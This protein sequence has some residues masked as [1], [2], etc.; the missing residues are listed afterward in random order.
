MDR[1]PQSDPVGYHQLLRKRHLVENIHSATPDDVVENQTLTRQKGG[2]SETLP[3]LDG[4]NAWA[5]TSVA[6]PNPARTLA[7]RPVRIGPVRST[8]PCFGCLIPRLLKT[9]PRC[10]VETL[11]MKIPSLFYGRAGAAKTS[12]AKLAKAIVRTGNFDLLQ[13]EPSLDTSHVDGL[14]LSAPEITPPWEKNFSLRYA[15]GLEHC[16]ASCVRAPA[17]WSINDGLGPLVSLEE[18][19]RFVCVLGD[20][21]ITGLRNLDPDVLDRYVDAGVRYWPTLAAEGKR[22]G[23]SVDIPGDLWMCWASMKF[24][25][26]NMGVP[27]AQVIAGSPDGPTGLLKYVGRRI[28]P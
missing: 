13:L 24:A 7:T 20:T 3:H 19:W 18:P 21:S 12:A 17:R 11:R 28:T 6:R 25:L 1:T 15:L 4:V 8:P 22:F 23:P 5:C 2:L 9:S 27:T 14:I 26:A 16:C 10:S